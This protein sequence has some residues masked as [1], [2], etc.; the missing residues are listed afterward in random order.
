M[1]QF[2]GP[3][4]FFYIRYI[5]Y[6]YGEQTCLPPYQYLDTTSITHPI[7]H[8]F[9]AFNA[10]LLVNPGA[11]ICS[12][13]CAPTPPSQKTILLYLLFYQASYY[14]PGIL[15]TASLSDL[16]SMEPS[17]QIPAEVLESIGV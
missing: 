16:G 10:A 14:K 15:L 13:A 1:K 12:S 2:S 17:I 8:L 7:H 4:N 3:Q 9:N 6:Y 5:N 11:F